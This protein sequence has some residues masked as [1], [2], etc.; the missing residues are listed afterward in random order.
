MVVIE[1]DSRILKQYRIQEMNID[2]KQK[3]KAACPT[4]D[5]SIVNCQ[6]SILNLLVKVVI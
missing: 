6:L 5:S 1:T 2:K 4:E 3:T